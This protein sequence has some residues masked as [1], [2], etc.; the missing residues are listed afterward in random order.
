MENSLVTIMSEAEARETVEQIREGVVR[1]RQLLLDLH[2]REGWRALGYASWKD[3]IAGEFTFSISYAYRLLSAER[4]GIEAGVS[5]MPESHARAL[6]SV[7][8]NQEEIQEFAEDYQEIGS[9]FFTAVEVKNIAK[10]IYLKRHPDLFEQVNNGELAVVP[11]YEIARAVESAPDDR[12]ESV[13]LCR[14]PEL[15]LAIAQAKKSELLD[16]ILGSQS[17]PSYSDYIPLQKA[18][19]ANLTAWEDVTSAEHRA[20]H[21]EQNRE[22]YDSL[23]DLTHLVIQLVNKM[24]NEHL[25]GEE[26]NLLQSAAA[27]AQSM[28]DI[29]RRG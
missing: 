10:N 23:R 16:E 4:V 2:D 12:K 18:T 15:A 28:I 25:T 29:I 14:D 6:S 24:Y 20:V 17:I 26:H 1:I 8:L 5:D 22:F 7:G 9:R 13:A 19:L 21:V 27:S 11:A 3:C